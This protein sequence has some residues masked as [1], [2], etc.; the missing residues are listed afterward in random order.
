MLASTIALFLALRQPPDQFRFVLYGD[1]RDGHEVHRKLVAL[2]MKQNPAFVVQTGDLVGTGSNDGQWKTYDSITLDMRKRVPVYPAPGNHDFGGTGYF[3]RIHIPP[4]NGTGQ[5]YSFSFGRWHFVSLS[6]DEHTAYKPP[7]EQ[8]TWLASDL[9]KAHDGKQN[10]AVFFHVPP[11]SIGGH[12]SDLDVRKTLC[13]LFE[14]YGVSL[15]M[16]GHDH[17]YYRT[18]RNGIT[19]VVSGGGGA[20]I[21]P[22]FPEA[23]G[24]IAGDKWLAGFHMIDFDVDGDH[25]KA[26]VLKPN[27]SVFDTFEVTARVPARRS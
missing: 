9:K 2:I 26:T 24:A 4:A 13:P 21:Y 8:Y 5:H 16:N 11:Y 3:D 14:K 6:V 18:V 1:T 10:I 7:A 25:M 20:P 27:G 23:R 19:Y 17:I 22:V 15:V 12:G